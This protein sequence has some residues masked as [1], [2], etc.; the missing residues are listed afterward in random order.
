MR[1]ATER[2]RRRRS[3]ATLALGGLAAALIASCGSEG[4][5][6]GPSA[7]GPSLLLAFTSN[8]P[9]SA[10]GNKDAYFYS[11]ASGG[12]A[13]R[14]PNL[15]SPFDEGPLALSGDGRW[16]AYNTTNPLVGTL[17]QVALYFVPTG[18]IHAPSTPATFI[19]ALNPS[20]SY[21]GRYLAFQ[22]QVG[23]FFEQDIALMDAFA[24]TLILTPRLHAIGALDFDPSLSGDGRLI[25]FT[26][27]RGGTLDIALYDVAGDSL[28]PLPNCNAPGANDLGVSIS[29]DG[30]YLA[31][32][33]NRAGGQGPFDVYVYDRVSASLL[34]MP[35]ANTPLADINPSLS[36]DGRWVAFTS[37]GEG[38][39]DTRLYDLVT[40]RTFPIPGAND[41]YFADRFPALADLH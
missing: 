34:P 31:F 13:F 25:A 18:V 2:P 30:R 38:G 3:I 20:L 39:S 19:G 1:P 15:D 28:I 12:L 17:T 29:R 4:N 32:H 35:G 37:E 6:M 21:D 23:S 16:L 14:P 22:N 7:V 33:S 36:P 8:R 27:S 26:T 24:D 10:P 9:P 41:P 5:P 11:C 40:H